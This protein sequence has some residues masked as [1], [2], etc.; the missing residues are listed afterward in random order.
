[1][2][3]RAAFLKQ[4]ATGVPGLDEILGGG[5]PEQGLYLVQGSAGVGKTTLALQFLLEGIRKGERALYIAL[6]ETREEICA[7]AAAHGW[8]VDALEVYDLAA[9]EQRTHNE[10]EQTM[11]HPAEVELEETT[12]PLLEEIQRVQPAR[13]V[14]DSLSEIRL[15][16]RDTLRYRRQLV[17]MKQLFARIGATALLV[18]ERLAANG[19]NILLTLAHGVIVLEKQ[20]PLYGST[21]RRLSVEKLRAVRYSEG[22]HD[23]RIATGG[24]EVFPRLVA[25]EHDRTFA[26]ET[27]SSGVP[28]LD[29]L[30]DGGLDRGT[31]TV[32]MGSAG[33]G[34]STLATQYAVAAA[35]RGERAAVYTFDES[36]AMWAARAASLGMKPHEHLAAGRIRITRIDPA[37]LTPGALASAM[38]VAVE[39][40]GVQLVVIDSINGY[41]QSV[42]EENYLLLHLHELLTYL[43]QRGVTT[44]LVM[45]QHGMLGHSMH[46]PVDV[47]YIADTVILQR[48]FEAAGEVRQAISVVKK[49]SG[50]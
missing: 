8:P 4:I 26:A 39:R 10:G 7:V 45:A 38:R 29:A 14:I 43:G 34:K 3:R 2:S 5:L 9:A 30:L 6:S 36:E 24:I 28:E 27:V 40:D 18:D 31:S 37:E 50:R 48:Y 16:A 17:A 42:P 1:M 35:A 21:R 32:L 49:R 22:F 33:T 25:A 44:L 23:Y 46:S 20:T 11:F 41:L 12:R 47:S 13:L 15:L 19:D